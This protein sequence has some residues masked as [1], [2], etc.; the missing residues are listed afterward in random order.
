ME[1][2]SSALQRYMLALVLVDV[3][4]LEKVRQSEMF[5]SVSKRLLTLVLWMLCPWQGAT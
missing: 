4:G 3:D 2:V 1:R 5:Q